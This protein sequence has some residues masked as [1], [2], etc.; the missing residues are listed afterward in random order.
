MKYYAIIVAGGKGN[1]MNNVVAKQFLVLNGLPVLMHTLA[2][3]YKCVLNPE[4][5][6]VMNIQQQSYW[7]ELCSTYKFEIPHQLVNGGAQRFDS[8]KSGLNAIEGEGI[9]AIHD[10]VRPLVSA[11][12]ILNSYQMA[13]D[14]GNAVAA[15]QPV[16]SVRRIREGNTSEPLNRDE[17]Y[18]IQTPQTFTT[19][20]LNQAYLQPF[21][22]EFTDD[23]SV[24]EMAGFAI[25]ILPGER[26]NIKI[27][28][29][30]DLDL[31]TFILQ[32]KG[33]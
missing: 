8:V 33:S 7:K 2:A 20:Q 19:V 23:A 6:L 18:L 30:Q 12:L 1:R 17:L 24:V 3:F 9:V 16:D 4:I 32:K 14:K 11:E 5:I 13:E 25:N 22:N 28:Y 26:N 10:A 15:V 27:T 29:P 21:T 31:A